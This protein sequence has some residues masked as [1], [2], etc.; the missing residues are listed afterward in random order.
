ME[1]H[2]GVGAGNHIRSVV[3]NELKQ[4]ER[5][6]WARGGVSGAAVAAQLRESE[7]RMEAKLEAMLAA[8][9]ARIAAMLGQT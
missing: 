8:S 3:K 9:E 6:A 4:F 5:N 1:D 7:A 2:D